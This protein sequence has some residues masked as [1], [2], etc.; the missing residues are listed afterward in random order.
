MSTKFLRY[1]LIVKYMKYIEKRLK[2]LILSLKKFYA[3]IFTASCAKGDLTV[4]FSPSKV[5]CLQR[6]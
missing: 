6:D 2:K 1:L 5:I 3:K 4:S